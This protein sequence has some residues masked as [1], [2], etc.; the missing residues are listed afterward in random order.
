MNSK[1]T[2]YPLA[3]PSRTGRLLTRPD[4][5]AALR[6]FLSWSQAALGDALHPPAGNVQANFRA[7]FTVCGVT[8]ALASIFKV[9]QRG[10]LLPLVDSLWPTALSLA[11]SDTLA[12]NAL[13][14]KLAVKLAQR[15]GL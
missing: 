8:Q 7:P 14:R 15:L 13:A 2:K 9:G 10:V 5:S 3:L 12:S 6:S 4:M 1:K 11:A